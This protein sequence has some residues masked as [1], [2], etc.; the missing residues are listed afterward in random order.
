MDMGNRIDRDKLIQTCASGGRK[1]GSAENPGQSALSLEGNRE[2]RA[3]VHFPSI[4][5]EIYDQDY[6]IRQVSSSSAGELVIDAHVDVLGN[7]INASSTVGANPPTQ[8][9]Q[10]DSLYRLTASQTGATPPG[11]LESYSNAR[12][13]TRTTV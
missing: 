8:V 4:L 10:Y 11:P 5:T 6:A 13:A 12:T 3:R 2:T 9:Y 1:P 7:M